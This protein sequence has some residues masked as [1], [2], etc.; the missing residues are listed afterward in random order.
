MKMIG[1]SLAAML[2]WSFAA[3]AHAQQQEQATSAADAARPIESVIVTARRFHME[4]LEFKDYEYGYSL[5][6]G[7]SV[8]FSRRVGRFYVAIKGQPAVEIFPT[9]A[10]QFETRGGARLVFTENGDA[11]TIDRYE[12]LQI[13]SG[14]QVATVPQA[15][16]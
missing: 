13:A 6:N 9:A 14:L 5:S 10:D 8:R 2:A 12:A 3:P 4:P 16:K 15:P 1:L 11:L 7:D